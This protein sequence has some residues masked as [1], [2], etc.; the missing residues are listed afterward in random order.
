MERKNPLIPD[1]CFSVKILSAAFPF[2]QTNKKMEE[3]KKIYGKHD[4]NRN[5]I[6]F[7]ELK[8]LQVFLAIGK[9][10]NKINIHIN[11]KG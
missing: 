1:F 2:T 8:K 10:K 5:D 4:Q 7:H 9:D 11:L 3:K 6:N